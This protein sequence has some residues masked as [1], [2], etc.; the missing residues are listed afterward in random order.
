MTHLMFY[1]ISVILTTYPEYAESNMF[2]T[3]W[4]RG[5]RRES[6]EMLEE[7]KDHERDI[8][9]KQWQVLGTKNIITWANFRKLF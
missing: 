9:E 1:L 3:S 8:L 6:C 2:Q 5:N 4:D 7:K